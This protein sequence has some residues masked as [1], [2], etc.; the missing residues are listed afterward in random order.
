MIRS[1]SVAFHLSVRWMG[2]WRKSA[3]RW[4][5]NIPVMCAIGDELSSGRARG[6]SAA[7]W[8]ISNSKLRCV[9][10]TPFGSAVVPD[11]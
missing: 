7:S 3:R 10:M 4:A 1:A 11:V 6:S 9:W 5:D 8:W 2:W